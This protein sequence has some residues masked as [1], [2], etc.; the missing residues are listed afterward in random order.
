MCGSNRDSFPGHSNGSNIIQT[1]FVQLINHTDCLKRA[2]P[3]NLPL[4][5]NQICA[6]GNEGHDVCSGDSGG[7]LT[8]IDSGNSPTAQSVN[9]IVGIVSFGADMPCGTAGLPS[10]YTRV[11]SYLSW[12]LENLRA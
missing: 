2:A 6:G 9:F 12:I 4:T 5:T 8:K 7:P 10:V 3:Y 1:T 11:M